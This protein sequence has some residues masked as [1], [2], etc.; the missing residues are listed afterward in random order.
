MAK[1][2]DT[3]SYIEHLSYLSHNPPSNKYLLLGESSYLKSLLKA[4]LKKVFSEGEDYENHIFYGDEFNVEQINELLNTLSFFFSKKIINFKRASQISKT[5]LKKIIETKLFA[6]ELSDILI[7]LEDDIPY[8]AL[9]K[10]FYKAFSNFTIITNCSI[11]KSQLMSWIN[12]RFNA[13]SIKVPKDISKT[14][15]EIACGDIDYSMQIVERLYLLS[16]NN[17]K[18]WV[19]ALNHFP[20]EHKS[21]I[22][23]LSDEMLSNNRAA[24]LKIFSNLIEEGESYESILYYLINHY[25]FLC[26]VKLASMKYK[27][28][29]EML[30][31]FKGKN[32]YRVE[33]AYLQIKKISFNKL[34]TFLSSLVNVE[35]NFKSGRLSDI[36]NALPL[37]IG[38]S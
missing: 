15:I 14:I 37:L 27:T 33:K 11:S 22:F 18:D 24:A 23:A 30:S 31:F 25:S 6:N 3:L 19:E 1:K 10:E 35:K 8:D 5:N 17:N 34:S 29:K 16:P 7:I 4:K 9:N 13:Y 38:K 21:I 28:K 26:E 12:A 36:S 2:E 32:E 20:R